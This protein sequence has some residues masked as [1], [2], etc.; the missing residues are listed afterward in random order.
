MPRRAAAGAAGDDRKRSASP[1]SRIAAGRDATAGSDRDAGPI[2]RRTARTLKAIRLKLRAAVHGDPGQTGIWLGRVQRGWLGYCAVP[3]GC[4][5]LQGFRH[6]LRFPWLRSLR[7]RPQKDRFP[8]ERLH[9][10]CDEPWPSVR[11]IHP[12][13]STRPAVRHAG[14]EPGA[15]TRTP[16]SVRGEAG[17]GLSCR[18]HALFGRMSNKEGCAVRVM[19]HVKA[20]PDSEAG[21][22][23]PTELLAAMG[24]YNQMLSGACVLP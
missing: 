19:D 6:R 15:L 10:P 14:Q 18:N 13:P 4:P 21:R 8:M 20:T 22:L 5:A 2:A 3:T 17:N 24:E 1:A 16:G 23:R 11:I 9:A 7:R 12:W